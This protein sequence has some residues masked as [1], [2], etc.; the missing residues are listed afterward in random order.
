MFPV[1]VSLDR[2]VMIYKNVTVEEYD[3]FINRITR[4]Q[5]F[6]PKTPIK[7]GMSSGMSAYRY[8]LNFGF[9][10]GAIRVDYRHNTLK[11]DI[12]RCDLRIEFNPNKLKYLDHEYISEYD[13]KKVVKQA[14]PSK[15]FFYDFNDVFSK[16]GFKNNLIGEYTGHIRTIREMDIA[17]DY[18][19]EK[20]KI[21]VMN[22][23]GKEASKYKGTEYWGNKH[24]NGYFKKYDKK[25]DIERLKPKRCNSCKGSD[26]PCER[27]YERIKQYSNSYNKFYD[28]YDSVTRLEFT[29]R[30]EN[31]TGIGELDRITEWNLHEIYKVVVMDAEKMEKFD[32]TVK[33]YL[34][35]Y[36]NNLMD[37]KEFSRRYKEKTKKALDELTT[38][39]LS[40]VMTK[41]FKTNILK[42]I[43][44]Y[45]RN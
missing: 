10:E 4:N 22:L 11:P 17:F 20:E 35:C 18:N 44:K 16:T 29:L 13:D 7:V 6:Y 8:N 25:K 38:I 43:T 26:K 40:Q 30:M 28:K 33:A 24:T 34:L 31:D 3:C 1:K 41:T 42:E 32:P 27:C 36:I 37:L 19:I 12:K 14:E 45:I 39:N 21:I 2:L 9:G 15:M 5:I 23:T